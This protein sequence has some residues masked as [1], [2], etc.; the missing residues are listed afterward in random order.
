[1]KNLTKIFMVVAVA[2]FAFSCV[3]DSTEDLGVNIEAGKGGGNTTVTLSLEES[4]TQLGV[5]AEGL[6]PVYWSEGDAIAING[7]ISAPLAAEYAGAPSADFHFGE[8]EVTYPYCVVYPAPEAMAIEDETT[9]EPTETPEVSLPENTYPVTFANVQ[10]YTVGT[11]APKS[12]PMYAYAVEPAEGE[13]AAPIQ[14]N[15]LTG[16][17]RLAVKGDVTLASMTVAA[18]GKIAGTFLIDCKSGTLTAHE[19]AVNNI[20]V[21]L[22][23]GGLKLSA[24]EATPIYVAVP[25]GEH[26]IYTITLVSDALAD[27]TM[28]VRF[29]SDFH[30]V[31]PGVVKEFGEITFTPNAASGQEGELVIV[32]A[33]QMKRLAQLSEVGQLSGVTKVTVGATIDMSGVADWHGIELLPSHIVFDGGSDKGYEITGLKAPLFGATAATIKNVKLTNVAIVETKQTIVGAIARRFDGTMTNCSAAGT[34]EVNN[35]T[36]TTTESLT[37]YNVMDIGGLVGQAGGATFENCENRVDVTLKSIAAATQKS[38]YVAIGGAIGGVH[39][40]SSLTNVDNYGDVTIDVRCEQ[41][42]YVHAAGIVGH[43]ISLSTDVTAAPDVKVVTKCDNHGAITTTAESTGLAAS[44]YAGITAVMTRGITNFSDN[45]NHGAI[46]CN[47]NTAG[48]TMGGVVGTH[49]WSPIDNC[50]NNAPITNNGD[51]GATY[52]GGIVGRDVLF[53]ITNCTNNGIIKNTGILTSTSNLYIGGISGSDLAITDEDYTDYALKEENC[54]VTN[55]HNKGEIIHEGSCNSI[56]LAGIVA[57]TT[58]ASISGCSNTA[59]VKHIGISKAN[60]YIAGI[61]SRSCGAVDQTTNSGSVVVGSDSKAPAS[62]YLYISGLI[63]TANGTLTNC[64]NSGSVSINGDATNKTAMTVYATGMALN[65]YDKIAEC[66]NSGDISVKNVVANTLWV[67]GVSSKAISTP[68]SSSTD[69]WQNVENSG[70]ITLNNVTGWI[71]NTNCYIGGI[72]GQLAATGSGFTAEN[73]VELLNWKNKGNITARN[74]GPGLASGA[75]GKEGRTIIAGCFGHM[76][77]VFY[78]WNNCDNEGDIDIDIAASSHAFVGGHA[79][80][81]AQSAT[82]TDFTCSMQNCDNSGDITVNAVPRTEGTITPAGEGFLIGGMYGGWYMATADAKQK[83][84]IENCTNSGSVTLKGNNIAKATSRNCVAGITADHYGSGSFI[85]CH[86]SGNIGVDGTA[87]AGAMATANNIAVAGIT[88]YFHPY[89]Q[90][91]D[92][93]GDWFG[94]TNTGKIYIQNI[95]ASSYLMTAGILGY[96]QNRGKSSTNFKDCGNSGELSIVNCSAKKNSFEMAGIIAYNADTEASIIGNLVHTGKITVQNVA[97]DLAKTY[98]GGIC[99][100][101][102][103]PITEAKSYCDIE[104]IGLKGYVGMVVGMARATATTST[105]CGVG[106]SIAFDT[107]EDNDP[108]GDLI[109]VPDFQSIAGNWYER[110]YTTDV[111]QATAEGDGCYLLTEKPAL[112][113]YTPAQ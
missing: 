79:G 88:A 55:C 53:A 11:F 30:K 31:E 19:E 3:A 4:R 89:Q 27:N 90:V 38:V 76:H 113:T 49:S 67:S 23:E 54:H 92:Q 45:H 17:L 109:L 93:I 86:N 105:K 20:T 1:M 84:L 101:T 98:I 102:V 112:P 40:L 41:S 9:E 14:M 7:A 58:T 107:K 95:N 46:T 25:A 18:E 66:N 50:T 111:T 61:C 78:N 72:I 35:T 52:I 37:K 91:A 16:V 59:A 36:F 69:K 10:P 110:I 73:R 33:A 56:F 8:Q 29:N 71:G 106:G 43:M 6:Y 96:N 21:V 34:L 32:N 103:T 75:T 64:S 81:V 74:F 5:K 44:T 104:A 26:G 24:T 57:R 28:V 47:D 48:R 22:P 62:G 65:F 2:M 94:C 80:Y 13:V 85:N 39:T 12:A 108:S 15:H 99:G 63:G 82:I 97:T 42:T 87:A 70:D 68:N 77:V 60:C 51:A 83:I 100:Y